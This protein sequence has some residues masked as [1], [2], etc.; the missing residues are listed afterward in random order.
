MGFDKI[1]YRDIFLSLGKNILFT[2]I[3]LVSLG[4]IK[5]VNF[6]VSLGVK[7]ATVHIKA[8]S[9]C[10]YVIPYLVSIFLPFA[11]IIGFI[12]LIN[13][14]RKENKIIALQNLSIGP[15]EIKKPIYVICYIV[16]VLNYLFYFLISPPFYSKFRDLQL[17]LKEKSI[18]DLIEADALKTYGNGITIYVKEKDENNN[19]R[20]IFISDTRDKNSIKAFSAQCGKISLEGIELQNGT[21]YEKSFKG[22][23]FL[24]FQNYLLKIHDKENILKKVDPYSISF[25]NMITLSQSDQKVFVALNQ[26]IIWP[27]YSLLFIVICFNLEWYFTYKYYMRT[28]NKRFIPIVLSILLSIVHFLLQNLG[29]AG[30]VV[31]YLIP[32]ITIYIISRLKI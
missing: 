12:L 16:V 1:Y 3:G 13:K 18:G 20:N 24:K 28:N 26:K 9:L 14:Y 25:S 4:L 31:T 21:Y 19:L 30:T 27:L 10:F 8:L 5:Y 6:I 17:S 15:S 29:L 7:S 2:T 22:S 23:G 11:T 32:T